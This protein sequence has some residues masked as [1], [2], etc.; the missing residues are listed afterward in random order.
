MGNSHSHLRSSPSSRRAPSR[1]PV[2]AMV[3]VEDPH[4]S[5][6]T[7][8]LGP[9][10]E[11]LLVP[12]GAGAPGKAHMSVGIGAGTSTQDMGAGTE[13][14]TYIRH[15]ERKID[16]L[17]TTLERDKH[18]RD[19][20]AKIKH[21]LQI[22]TSHSAG[23]R[24]GR[25][26]HQSPS[27]SRE[28]GRLIEHQ[29]RPSVKDRLEPPVAKDG[30]NEGGAGRRERSRSPDPKDPKRKRS[31]FERLGV[32]SDSASS[33]HPIRRGK[34]TRE[35]TPSFTKI[36]N[37]E[38]GLLE[39][40]TKG[41]REHLKNTR[42]KSPF[43][44][45][46]REKGGGSHVTE[47]L[48]PYARDSYRK[49]QQERSHQRSGGT[50]P[51]RKEYKRLDESV[52]KKRPATKRPDG[53]DRSIRPHRDARLRRLTT[54]PFTREIDSV[55]P[56]KGFTQPKFAKYD[57][58]TEAYTH[59][60]QFK[61]VMSLFLRNEPSDDAFLCKVF[62]ASLGNLRLTWFNQLPARS[63]SSFDS[64]CDAFMARFVTS[65]KH[66]KEIDS[67]LSLRKCP[68]ETLRQYAGRYWDL[69]NEIEGCDGVISARGFKLGLTAQDEQVYDD[70]ARNKP[71]SMKDLMTRIEGWC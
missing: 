40:Q 64:L 48:G 2:A 68:D 16:D 61:L 38:E 43:V 62:P 41:Y 1:P 52:P 19:E 70:L 67:L 10:G 71:D 27:C 60:V 13:L 12:G 47:R 23:S 21:L 4:P 55:T 9:F 33:T 20:L 54:S 11:P 28:G 36:A 24:G 50:P 22:S 69:F 3:E 14:H 59:L 44:S 42:T 29:S 7:L 25:R 35:P 51:K 32:G 15:L 63:I 58:K 49:G 30:R 8:G 57:G 65:N 46:P 17:S 31:A 45:H 6:T 39:F 56:P 53:L 34:G 18:V 26:T 66:E 37:D 5:E